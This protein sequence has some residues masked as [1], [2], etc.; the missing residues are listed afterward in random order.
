[1]TYNIHHGAGVDGRLDLDRIAALILAEKADVVALQEVDRGVARTQQ[2]DLAG[3]LAGLTGMSCVFSNNYHYQGGE[4]GNAWLT[5]LEIEQTTNT[6]YRMLREGE[7]RGLL[8]VVLRA[9]ANRLV[10]MNTHLDYRPDPAERLSNATELAAAAAHYAPLPV[11]VCGDFNASPDSPTHAAMVRTFRDVWVEIGEG[12]GY[13][14]PSPRPD[15]R[16]DYIF[17]NQDNHSIL[18]RRAWVVSSEAS[19]HRPLMLEFSIGP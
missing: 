6:H 15:R 17:L 11:L 8:Q 1:M 13:T 4:Y 12:Q 7:Q 18:L 10:V 5:R 9:D 3:E 19:D 2:R 16:I 14:F